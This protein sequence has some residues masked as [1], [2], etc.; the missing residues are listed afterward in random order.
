MQ[1]LIVSMQELIVSQQELIVK[2]PVE[3]ANDNK[4][5]CG[6]SVSMQN[7]ETRG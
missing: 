6:A 4:N 2:L 3:I 5:L 7:L 1:E